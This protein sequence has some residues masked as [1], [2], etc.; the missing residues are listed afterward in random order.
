[1]GELFKYFMDNFAM[2]G[3][4]DELNKNVIEVDCNFVFSNEISKNMV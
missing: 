4:V 1:M 3:K 2:R